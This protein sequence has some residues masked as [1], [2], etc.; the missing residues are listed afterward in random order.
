MITKTGQQALEK[1]AYLGGAT[2]NLFGQMKNLFGQ[3]LGGKLRWGIGG[4]LTGAG[5]ASAGQKGT[6]YT[7]PQNVNM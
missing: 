1:K 6:N 7:Q 5:V 4:G 3:N 2:K